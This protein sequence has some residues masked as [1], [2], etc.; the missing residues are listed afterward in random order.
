MYWLRHHTPWFIASTPTLTLAPHKAPD[1]ALNLQITAG[2]QKKR[3]TQKTLDLITI[4]SNISSS[5]TNYSLHTNVRFEFE[6]Y[7]FWN[8]LSNQNSWIHQRKAL[9]HQKKQNKPQVLLKMLK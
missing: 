6:Q 3:N 9:L 8:I 1:K 4:Y 2:F 7:T 5:L